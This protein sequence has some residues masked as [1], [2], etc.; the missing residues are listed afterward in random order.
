M[1]NKIEKTLHY[2][3]Y[4]AY[5]NPSFFTGDAKVLLK[6]YRDGGYKPAIKLNDVQH[7]LSKQSVYGL[8]RKQVNKFERNK[9]YSMFQGDIFALDIA[10]MNAFSEQNDEVKYILMGIDAF[11]KKGYAVPVNGKKAIDILN[12]FKEMRGDIKYTIYNI[13][14]D[15]GGEFLGEFKKYCKNEGINLYTVQGEQKN[16]IVERFILTVKT[17]LWKYLRFSGKHRWLEVLPKMIKTY[18]E[19]I[20][21][22]IKMKPNSVH[23]G[24]SHIIYSRLYPG[25]YIKKPP[26]FKIGDAVRHSIKIGDRAKSYEGKYSIPIF[27]I[28]KI[29]YNIKGTHPVYML[30]EAFSKKEYPGWWY[31]QQLQKVDKATFAS[32][33]TMYDINVVGSKGKKVLIKYVGY[34]DKPVWVDKSL[35]IDNFRQAVRYK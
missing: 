6:G 3:Y 8:H 31:K 32:K 18:N 4:K 1:A 24:N 7:F 15:N 21:R 12:G 14:V 17:R 30:E 34:K 25:R 35:I 2:L 13:S 10:D 26:V 28:K 29:K 20:H 16:A 11:S 19:T 33:H 9:I 5:G 27:L 23:N 22:S